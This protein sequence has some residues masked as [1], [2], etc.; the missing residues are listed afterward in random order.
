M[1]FY[2][3]LK[4]GPDFQWLKQDG[5]QNKTVDHLK[6]GHKLCPENDHLNTGQSGFQMMTVLS[7]TA[8]QFVVLIKEEQISRA[9]L[10][11]PPWKRT[12]SFVS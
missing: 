1:T 10:I 4:C 7:C 5:S 11:V 3:G 8:I 2:Y 6:T 9:L 12:Y